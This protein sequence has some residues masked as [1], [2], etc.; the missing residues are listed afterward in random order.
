MQVSGVF[1]FGLPPDIIWDRLNDPT[2]LAS[3]IPGCQKFGETSPSKYD[4][5]SAFGLGPLSIKLSGQVELDPFA[6]PHAYYMKAVAQHWMGRAG[7]DATINLTA[8]PGGT[9]FRYQ[10]TLE[11]GQGLAS[12]GSQ[13]I[14]GTVDSLSCRFFERL[15]VKLD[16][17]LLDVSDCE[18]G[19]FVA[20][21]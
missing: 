5:V 17:E 11:I 9:A 1:G 19:P 16:T 4:V 6:P 20:R 18:F 15:A 3:V 2:F 10:A 14:S 12:V 21:P 7:G 8:V 13:V